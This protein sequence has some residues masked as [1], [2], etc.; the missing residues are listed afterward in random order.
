MALGTSRR[1]ESLF[2]LAPAGTDARI[3]DLL[4]LQRAAQQ[5]NSILDLDLLLDRIVNEA[6]ATFGAVESSILLKNPET[7]E[8]EFAAVHGCTEHMKCSCVPFG[9]GL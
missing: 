4:K 3:D 8:F 7:G 9:R 6:A 2:A 5:I 1:Q